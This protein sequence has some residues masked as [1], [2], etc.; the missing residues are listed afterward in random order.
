MV[1]LKSMLSGVSSWS[2]FDFLYQLYVA[3]SP[4]LTKVKKPARR[5]QSPLRANVVSAGKLRRRCEMMGAKKRGKVKESCEP[6]S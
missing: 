5:F 4:A 3:L 1:L 6:N 2:M